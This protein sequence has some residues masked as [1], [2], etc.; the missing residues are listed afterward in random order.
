ML[1]SN[2]KRSSGVI[3][4]E[5]RAHG[6]WLDA[7]ELEQVA[8]F[9]L[10]G[11]HTS[12][13]LEAEH[14]AAE[15]EAAAAF[16]RARIETARRS[17]QRTARA[18]QRQ[19]ARAVPEDPRLRRGTHHGIHGQAAR[20]ARRHHRVGRRQ[21][22]HAG[23]ALPA[24][25]QPDQERR[26]ADR[27]PG[28]DRGVRAPGPDR[29][30]VRAGSAPARDAQ[31]ADALHARGLDVRL[32]QPVQGR[33]LL[34][35]HAR[36]SPTC[37][38]ARR[39]RCRCATP[40]FGPVR[41]RAFG[42]YTLRAA[43]PKTLLTELVGTDGEYAADEIHEL[44]RS[45][46]NQSLADVIAKAELG[47]LDLA[48]HYPTLSEQ[49]R[50]L[51]R[52]RIDDEYGLEIPQLVIVN[53]SVPAEVEQAL[54]A[55]ASMSVI[56]DLAAYQQY[57]VGAA[58]PV[59]AA[60]P[61]GGLAGAGVGVGMGMAIAGRFAPGGARPAAPPPPP[62]T[63]WHVV[64]QGQAIGP[65]SA[66]AARAGGRARAASGPTHSCGARAW[67]AGRPRAACP[68]SRRC[69]E[70]RPRRRGDRSG[71]VTLPALPICEYRSLARD[72]ARGVGGH[73]RDA[74]SLVAGDRQGQAPARPARESLVGQRPPAHLARVDDRAD[75]VRRAH[76]RS[77]DGL[78]R[79][80]ASCCSTSDGSPPGRRDAPA[81]GRGLLPRHVH[82]ARR[83][84]SR[85]ADPDA[86]LRDRGRDPVRSRRDAIA[87]TIR[88]RPSV[89]GARRSRRTACS[90]NSARASS[91]SAARSTSSGDRST[92]P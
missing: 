82:R 21:P 84:G 62:P 78:H 58:T 11:G 10:A 27:A 34:R 46:I 5:C 28:P 91:G 29:R 39:T 15:R 14:Q 25:P 41:V 79:P 35:Q 30:R 88:M 4:D 51:V 50:T 31:P 9:I 17:A 74:A 40:S 2:Y 70:R 85:H 49:V 65:W 12:P 59:A 68:R 69:S 63:A 87:P 6:T 64:E 43:D 89:S 1:R 24:L 16:A 22:A 42:T 8:G 20:R 83:A 23:L 73:P 77:G 33:G 54:D 71:G 37:A 66:G 57:Q 55:R 86:A 56:G 75:P 81:L 52:E 76:V 44:L 72:S 32:R 53:I 90:G 60:N 13:M 47:V 7:D 19:P 80:S 18:H 45:I 36:R 61:A 92:S 26:A 3:L 48:A 38:G 67:R